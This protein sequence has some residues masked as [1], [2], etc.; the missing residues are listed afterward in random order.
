MSIRLTVQVKT[1]LTDEDRDLLSGLSV[2]TMALATRG[3]EEEEEPP[4]AEQTSFQAVLFAVDDEGNVAVHEAQ[5]PEELDEIVEAARINAVRCKS[6][7]VTG[8]EQCILLHDH[9]GIHM[10]PRIN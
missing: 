4:E 2:F 3:K 7:S 6:M 9:D 1:P 8:T 5:S 10:F